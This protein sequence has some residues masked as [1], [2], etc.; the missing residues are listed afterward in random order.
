MSTCSTTGFSTCSSRATSTCCS[1]ATRRSTVRRCCPAGGCASR[2]MRRGMRTPCCGPDRRATRATGAER[3][4]L[5]V[6]FEVR[7]APGRLHGAPFGDARPS[8]GARIVAH[9][10]HRQAAPVHRWFARRGVRRGGGADL[11]G[12]SPVHA[13]ATWNGCAQ[14]SSRRGASGV[15]TTEKDMVRLLPFRP[16]PF[17]A[18]WQRLEV[19][20]EPADAFDAWLTRAPAR[21]RCP[22]GGAARGARG[23]RHR[24]EL[25]AVYLV[26]G[27]IRAMPRGIVRPCGRLLGYAFYLF[28]GV[29]RGVADTNLAMAFPQRTA[30]GAADDHARDVRPLRVRAAGAAEV[31][32]AQPG[33]RCAASSSSRVTTA[34]VRRMRAARACS[35]SPATSV[36]GRSTR[37]CTPSGSSRWRCSPARSTTP[38]CTSCSSRCARPPATP[39]SIARARSGACCAC[40]SP[41]T[42]W[43]C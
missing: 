7:R 25:A 8:A 26:R 21:G 35:S 18:A 17:A 28:D 29:H 16:L 14:R 11:A 24:L 6:A 19:T 33:R 23:M 27:L 15:V 5:G 3:L 36:T 37:S 43:R 42:G 41:G 12:S 31:Q 39:S 40:C 1:R 34:P 22:R 9:G 38:G 2:W 10:G 30:G 4:G 13:A 20:V 32:H